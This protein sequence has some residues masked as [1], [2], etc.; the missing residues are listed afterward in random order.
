MIHLSYMYKNKLGGLDE[1]E[2]NPKEMAKKLL[3]EAAANRNPTA[4]YM[5]N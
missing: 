1:K 3:E 5:L 2:D 4:L